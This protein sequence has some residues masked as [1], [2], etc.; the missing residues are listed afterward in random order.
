MNPMINRMGRALLTILAAGF[1]AGPLWAGSEGVKTMTNRIKLILADG[2][3]AVFSMEDNGTSRDFLARLPL[4]LDFEDYS[5]TEKIAT[6]PSPL[7]TDG[8]PAGYDP[9]VGD[10]CLYAPW[11]NLCIFYRDFSYAPGLVKMGEVISGKE[12]LTRIEGPVR[13]ERQ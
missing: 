12:N 9:R 7:S 1:L 13:I 5:R 6:P 3:E 2:R 10:L 11:E 8:A 4:T